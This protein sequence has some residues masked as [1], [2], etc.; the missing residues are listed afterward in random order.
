MTLRTRLVAGLALVLAALVAAGLSVGAVYRSSLT[1]QLDERLETYAAAAPQIVAR[2]GALGDLGEL[3]RGSLG[4]PAGTPAGGPPGGQV[5]DIF[6]GV[7]RA[8]GT[9]QPVVTPVTDPLAI[10]VLDPAAA[11]GNATTVATRGGTDDRMRV[12]VVDIDTPVLPSPLQIVVGSSTAEIETSF[13]RLRNAALG[14]GVI[15]AAVLGLVGWWVVRLGLRPIRTMTDAADAIAAGRTDTR[16]PTFAAGTEAARL[17]S[18]LNTMIDANRTTEE[19]LRQFVADASHELRTP[20]TTLRG[21]TALHEAGG[22]GDDA[23]VADAMRRIGAE[24]ARMALMVDDLLLLADLDAQRP[25]D[26]QPI[27]VAQLLGDLADDARVVQPDR[28]IDVHTEPGVN[29]AADQ[30]RLTQAVAALISNALRHTPPTA[31][32]HLRASTSDSH[33]MIDVIDEGPG[34]AHE[35]LAHLF[36]RFYRVDP[37][38]SRADGGSGLGLA[39]VAAIA[40]AHGGSATATSTSGVGTTFRIAL[41]GRAMVT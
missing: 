25:L 7:V 27:D 21:Y 2:S 20:L 32:L 34:I 8:D 23:A 19:R 36:E 31:A 5:S 4:P 11:A 6:L 33:V 37:S 22:L 35:H 3:G 24:A 14:A 13:R 30:A 28:T 16:V 40:D 17:G 29:I 12:L 26:L 15:V 39:I 9:I 18:A 1:E 10:P 38:R 41:P